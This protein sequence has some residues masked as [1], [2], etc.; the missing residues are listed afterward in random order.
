ME[1]YSQGGPAGWSV[2]AMKAQG[3][4]LAGGLV[5]SDSLATSCGTRPAPVRAARLLLDACRTT[6]S[7]RHT[8][9]CAFFHALL[10]RRFASYLTHNP[11]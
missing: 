8:V 6:M 9:L 11:S 1:N 7:T 3:M 2:E 4:Y 10:G 5:C